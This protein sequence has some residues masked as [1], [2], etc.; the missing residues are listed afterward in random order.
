MK[1]QKVSKKL[2]IIGI[3]NLQC[4]IKGNEIYILEINPKGSRTKI[5]F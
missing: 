5:H 4:A 1:L 2:G 3:G